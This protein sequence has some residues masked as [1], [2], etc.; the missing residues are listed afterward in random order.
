MR[1]CVFVCV[2]K[3]FKKMFNMGAYPNAR[4]KHIQNE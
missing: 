4:T 1:V 2:C 3:C